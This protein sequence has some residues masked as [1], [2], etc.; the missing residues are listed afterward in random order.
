MLLYSILYN[1]PK[2]FELKVSCREDSLTEARTEEDTWSGS[3]REM[4]NLTTNTELDLTGSN[5]S[6]SYRLEGRSFR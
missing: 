2:F 3:G 4:L 1:I 5:R 6:C